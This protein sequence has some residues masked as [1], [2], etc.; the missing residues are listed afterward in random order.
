MNY[1]KNDTVASGL[2]KP[3]ITAIFFDKLWLP[4]YSNV[5]IDDI[6]NEILL[7]DN[8]EGALFTENDFCSRIYWLGMV[9]NR[10]LY[11]PGKALSKFYD[12]TDYDS[13]EQLEK[14]VEDLIAD[15]SKLGT[16]LK[17]QKSYEHFWPFIESLSE[18]LPQLPLGDESIPNQFLTSR[19]RNAALIKISKL[20]MEK[21]NIDMVPIFIDKTEFEKCLQEVNSPYLFGELRNNLDD[22]G[23][24]KI[25]VLEICIK[26][27]PYPVEKNLTW[28]QVLNIRKDTRSVSSVRRLK[29][30]LN[31]ELVGRGEREVKE[32]LDEAIDNYI[33]ALKKHGIMTG[34]GGITTILSVMP[35]IV[36]AVSSEP[37]NI[38]ATGLAV[39]AG[40]ITFTAKQISDFI[41]T[42][43]QPI[44]FLHELNKL[45]K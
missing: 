45:G 24:R 7:M 20:L 11:F 34:I 43:R 12:Y 35:Q 5:F 33:F 36:N 28:E 41:T 19:Y 31:T 6:P 8:T 1:N 21:H 32:L 29:N 9:S 18:F 44:A 39:S 4:Y 23:E 16:M 40:I 38:V 42:K 26:N 37:I 15:D 22:M 2:V 14:F 13:T 17:D 10:N 30:M 25:N 27:I 3:K